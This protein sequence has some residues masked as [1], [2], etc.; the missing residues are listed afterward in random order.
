MVNI[1]HGFSLAAEQGLAIWRFWQAANRTHIQG[2]FHRMSEQSL[3]P[4]SG[5]NACP[6]CPATPTGT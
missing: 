5:G 4:K 1:Y 6:S 3:A 2:F